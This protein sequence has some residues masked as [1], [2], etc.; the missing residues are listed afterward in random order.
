VNGDPNLRARLERLASN[1]GDPPERGL[2][3]VAARR[4]RR[5]GAFVTA[6][7][8]AVLLGGVS[9]V[10]GGSPDDDHVAVS[11]ARRPSHA[12]AQL[13]E[14][15]EVYC[16]PGGIDIPVASVRP[17]RDGMH[18]RVINKL[19]TPVEVR[20]VKEDVWT[21]RQSF[22]TGAVGSMTQPV[23]PGSVQIGCFG[24]GLTDSNTVELVDVHSYYKEPRL[25]CS[26][27]EQVRVTDLRDAEDVESRSMSTT[28]RN[29]LDSQGFEV[30]ELDPRPVRGYLSQHFSDPTD[31]PMVQV[32]R[33][34][35]DDPVAFVHLR[36]TDDQLD[37]PWAAVAIDSCPSFLEEA[38]STEA[39]AATG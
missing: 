14:V 23:P 20:V 37:A 11:P 34:D 17:Q 7:A 29:A 26:E 6:L 33:R 31:D 15:V 22:P 3:R 27:D 13:P 38:T 21:G 10:I 18:L 1:A 36:R 12:A 5:R 2:D 25:E 24:A 39:T 28:T 19:A 9:L 35:G 4:H 16:K 32:N 30:D 8:L